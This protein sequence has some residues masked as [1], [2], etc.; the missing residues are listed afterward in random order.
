MLAA[1]GGFDLEL[2]DDPVPGEEH[3]AM[4]AARVRTA[5]VPDCPALRLV[6]I[7][8]VAACA[9]QPAL[10]Q[11]A[12]P[13]GQPI[14]RHAAGRH[15]LPRDLKFS[16]LTTKDGLAQDN[17]VAILQDRR[18]FM[19][20]ATGGGLNRYDGN[21]FLVYKNNPTDPG[22]ISHNLHFGWPLDWVYIDSTARMK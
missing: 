21:S 8:L 16:H 6:L 19:W 12:A 9:G 14:I 7:V 2:P 5:S 4:T 1:S 10:A 3:R 11:S 18:G 13:G 20:F 17:V 22:S 15:P